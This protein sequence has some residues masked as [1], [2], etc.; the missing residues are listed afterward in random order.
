MES[1]R[2]F[3][4]SYGDKN[5]P[6]KSKLKMYDLIYYNPTTNPMRKKKSGPE[7]TSDK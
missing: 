7:N 3:N 5:P 1:R 4:R 6:D 2:E